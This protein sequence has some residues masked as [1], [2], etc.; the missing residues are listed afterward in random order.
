MKVYLALISTAALALA[1]CSQEAPKPAETAPAAA[2]A[3]ASTPAETASSE[4]VAA[5]SAPAAETGCEVTIESTDQMKYNLSEIE[6]KRSCASVTL[7]LKHTGTMPKA[8]MGHNIVIS[9]TADAQAIAAEG[10]AASLANDFVKADDPRIVTY[11]A[12]IGGG[13][14]TSVSFDPAKLTSGES[15]EFF[16]T[17]PGHY[18]MM[19][20]NVKL[21]D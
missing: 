2:S 21:V 10:A 12:L 8:A 7:H 4:T 14:E 5:A 1:A 17:F 3:A 9:K 16:C 13:E 18:A 6:I 19:K 15:Y 11:T 20:G